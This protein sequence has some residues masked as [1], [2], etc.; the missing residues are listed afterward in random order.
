MGDSK[1]RKQR[2]FTQHPFCYFCGGDTPAVQVDH[3]PPRA[4]FLQ[5][6]WPLA[7][8]FPACASCNNG[9]SVQDRLFAFIASGPL[10]DPIDPVRRAEWVALG[11]E[12][13][14]DH[15]GLLDSMRLSSAQKKRVAWSLGIAPPEGETYAAMGL[16]RLT[17]EVT[18]AVEAILRKIAKALH[19]LQTGLIVPWTACIEVY[20]YTNAELLDGRFPNEVLLDLPTVQMTFRNGRDLSDQFVYRFGVSEDKRH[21]LYI[22]KFGDALLVGLLVSFDASE[23]GRDD[24]REGDPPPD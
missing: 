20:S 18:A 4:M 24:S 3:V 14:K 5:R 2:F 1:R 23:L 15:P 17:P 9:S 7:H 13:K 16:L 6:N 22:C 10:K 8:E 21:G 11:R 12:I 19:Y